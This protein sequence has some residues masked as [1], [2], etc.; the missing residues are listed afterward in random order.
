VTG[1]SGGRGRATIVAVRS[2]TNRSLQVA[3]TSATGGVRAC[4][5][6]PV[7]A[8]GTLTVTSLVRIGGGPTSDTTIGSVRGPGGEAASLRVTSHSL[9]AYYAGATKVT[10]STAVAGGAWYRMSITLHLAARTWDWSVAT[11]AGSRIAGH[12]GVAW[13]QPEV[14]ALDTVCGQS[15]ERPGAVLVLDDLTVAR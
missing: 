2:T 1:E 10:T 4:T 12:A 7:T 15:G 8:T 11:A 6:F 9:L 13:R 14:T 5:D 3:T